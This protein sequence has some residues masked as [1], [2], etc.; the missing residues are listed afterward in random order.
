M[1]GFGRNKISNKDIDNIVFS[2]LQS[3]DSP[4]NLGTETFRAKFIE[5]LTE[6]KQ[7]ADDQEFGD[8][9]R[10]AICGCIENILRTTYR[11]Y[12]VDGIVNDYVK[13]ARNIIF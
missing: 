2:Y 6:L 13:T 10:S 9:K 4:E 1:F 8:W 3:L 5:M 7:W 12:G 11:N